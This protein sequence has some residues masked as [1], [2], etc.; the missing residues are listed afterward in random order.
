[1]IERIWKKVLR[2]KGLG[3]WSIPAA[4]LRIASWGYSLGNYIR[5]NQTGEQY[6]PPVPVI[7]IGNITVGGTGK[8]PLVEFI[9]RFLSREG[10]RVG[11]V[12]SGYG[13]P[14][15]AN[16]MATGHDI[17]QMSVNETGDEVMLL[18][19]QL[20]HAMFSVHSIKAEAA[21]NLAESGNID[22]IIVDDGFQHRRLARDIDIVAFDGAIRK[23]WWHAFPYGVMREPFAA[24]TRAHVVII[25]RSNFARDLVLLRKKIQSSAPLAHHYQAKFSITGVVGQSQRWPVKYLEDKS[26]FLFAGIGNFRS[27]RKQVESLAANVHHSLELSDHQVYN[28]RLLERIR[29]M[30]NEYDSD[31]IVTTFKDWVKLGTFDFGREVCYLTQSID[32]DPGEEKLIAYLQSQ[33]SL[34]RK[35]RA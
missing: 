18:A 8:T 31:V 5:S 1:M 12:S 34:K 7:S 27:F 19:H 28:Y 35:V 33:L 10:I 23:V 24:L 14:S 32:L 2:R 22:V 29:D 9:A 4:I 15:Q 20:P 17:S 13:R 25:T 30:A 21:R 26:V 6:R 16:I 3:I 11:I